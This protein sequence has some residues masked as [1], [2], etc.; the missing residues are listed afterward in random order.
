MKKNHQGKNSII[1][2]L[3]ITILSLVIGFVFL[4]SRLSQLKKDSSSYRVVFT[5]VEKVSSIK[6]GD[7]E[8]FGEGKIILDGHEIELNLEFYNIHDEMTFLVTIQN[9]GG[10]PSRIIDILENNKSSDVPIKIS[11]DK[12]KNVIDSFEEEKIKIKVSYSSSELVR[13]RVK[14]KLGLLTESVS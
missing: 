2:F 14:Y 8:A 10:I 1:I 7:E 4:S 3:C 11:I 12:P 5:K 9:K 6:G 13:K